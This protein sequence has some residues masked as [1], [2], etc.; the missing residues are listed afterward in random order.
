[1]LCIRA[2][3]LKLKNQIK[4][5]NTKAGAHF[6]YYL[7]LGNWYLTWSC[8]L[9][10]IGILHFHY[11]CIQS[12]KRYGKFF[13]KRLVLWVSKLTRHWNKNSAFLNQI[14]AK[15]KGFKRKYVLKNWKKG[16]NENALYNIIIHFRAVLKPL[17]Q[18]SLK[19]H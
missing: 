19:F 7:L 11:K 17:S 12:Q 4:S 9:P 5:I 13:K 6:G 15:D 1:M 3:H 8:K 16:L 2:E 10:D 18:R 14:S